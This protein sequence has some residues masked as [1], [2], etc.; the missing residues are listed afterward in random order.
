MARRARYSGPMPFRFAA[1]LLLAL[2]LP[3]FAQEL[4]EGQ[5]KADYDSWLAANPGARASVLSFE[6]WQQAAKVA[7]VLPTW[8]ITRTAS[9]CG[10][11]GASRSRFRP[12]ITGRK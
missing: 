12:S 3:A 8:Q 5:A 6:S 2:P 4:P 11:A 7:G 9:M 10:N 1:L